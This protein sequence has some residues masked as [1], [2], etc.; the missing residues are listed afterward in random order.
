MSARGWHRARVDPMTVV[1]HI[2]LGNTI[3]AMWD[4]NG[5]VICRHGKTSR[6][7]QAARRVEKALLTL[8]CRLDSEVCALTQNSD[9][10]NL[11]THVYYGRPMVR[12]E[13]ADS[14]DAFDGWEYPTGVAGE[15]GA[16]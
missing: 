13:P 10:R 16:A 1:D 7:T 2:A 14:T 8:K 11:A 5:V 6:E 15:R 12:C 9:P 3:K 4:A